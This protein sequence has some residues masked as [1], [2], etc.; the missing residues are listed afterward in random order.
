MEKTKKTHEEKT[1]LIDALKQDEINWIRQK[2]TKMKKYRKVR[3][4]RSVGGDI[5]LLVVLF[6][7]GLFSAYPLIFTI[8]NSLKGL[9][10]IFVFPPRLFPRNIT[11]ENFVDLFNLIG[12][13][14]VPISRYFVNTLTITLFGTVGH[15]FLASLC[16]YPL[17][18]HSFPGRHLINQL[19]VYS[20]M[21]S[22]VVTQIPTYM[23]VSWLGL[24]DTHMAIIIPAWGFT[25]GL[26]LMRQF[27]VTI[28]DELLEA[29]KIDGANEYQTFFHVVMPLVKP[30]WLTLIILLFQQLWGIDG[31]NYIF[32]ENLKPL[33]YALSQI[34]AGGVARTGTAAAVTVIM[35]IVPITVFIINQSKMLDTMAHSGLK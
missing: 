14:Q 11:F 8:T 31:G 27:M 30:A 23:I 3:L 24:I 32:T 5:A 10:E 18:K 29:A 22:T 35:L 17:A 1:L 7:F 28:P 2:K 21:F 25:L 13:T 6:L 19:I 16:A 15:V 20:L 4:S 34:V 12:N 26:F 33:S 9:D